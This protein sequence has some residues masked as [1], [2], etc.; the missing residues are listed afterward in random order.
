MTDE[1]IKNAIKEA[2]RFI[3]RAKDALHR[4]DGDEIARITGTK[5]TA[6]MK[7]ASLE[8]TRALAEMRRR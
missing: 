2:E 3:D 5:E 4:L 6:A 7:R 1:K 8:L